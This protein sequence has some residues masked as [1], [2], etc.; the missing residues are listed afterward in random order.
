[1]T[2]YEISQ[3]QPI[4]LIITAITNSQVIHYNRMHHANDNNINIF[5]F[6]LCSTESVS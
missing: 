1:M 3:N 6:C 5:S 4:T 2:K